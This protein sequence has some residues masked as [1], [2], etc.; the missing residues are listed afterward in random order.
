M[1]VTLY[2]RMVRVYYV[3]MAKDEGRCWAEGTPVVNL[4]AFDKKTLQIRLREWIATG[5]DEGGKLTRKDFQIRSGLMNDHRCPTVEIHML[6][7]PP[8]KLDWF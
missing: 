3:V 6:G 5:K 2:T 1:K 8:E 7:A 4:Y